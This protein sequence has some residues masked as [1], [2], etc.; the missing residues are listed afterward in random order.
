LYPFFLSPLFSHKGVCKL[1]QKYFVFF[2]LIYKPIPY[3]KGTFLFHTEQDMISYINLLKERCLLEKEKTVLLEIRE[4]IYSLLG[5]AFLNLPNVT[6]VEPILKQQLFEEFP[7]E[8]DTQDFKQGLKLL[9]SWAKENENSKLDEVL[10]PIRQ[11]YTKLFIGPANL[12]APPWESVY[13]TEEKLTFGEP[14]LS[15][16]EFYL[17]HG[18]Q[19]ERKNSEP[20]DHFGLEMEFMARL[21]AKQQQ[22]LANDQQE[23]AHLIEKE[24][25]LFLKEHILKWANNFTGDIIRNASTPYFRG[26]ALLSRAY[27]TWDIAYLEQQF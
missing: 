4:F 11:D 3:F 19:Y 12:W 27:L 22:E 8:I 16:R 18:L 9:R 23:K 21:I 7:L 15:V 14:T 1:K 17:R 10:T 6:H 24:Q 5:S 20:D 26:L 25:I 2:V 13:L